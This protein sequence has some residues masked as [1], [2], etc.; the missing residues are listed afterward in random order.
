MFVL[1][2]LRAELHTTMESVGLRDKIKTLVNQLIEESGGVNAVD[3]E[4]LVAELR[5]R[6]GLM[7]LRSEIFY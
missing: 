7:E 1:T 5:K 3:V 2:R 4:V 6:T